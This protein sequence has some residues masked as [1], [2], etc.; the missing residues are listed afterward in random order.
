[1]NDTLDLK[2][3]V[4]NATAQGP[5]IEDD[6]S[7]TTTAAVVAVDAAGRRVRVSVRGGSVWLPAVAGRYSPSS[8]ARILVDPTSARPVLVLGPVAPRAP[9]VLALVTAGPTSGNLTVTF[10]GASVVLPAPMGAYTVGQSAWVALDDWGLPVLVIG[11]NAATDT[12]GSSG[13]GG[14]G[15][16]PS[17]VVAYATIG[18]QVTGTWRSSVARWDSWNPNRYGLGATPIYQGNA[19]GSGQ[20]LGFAGYGD[21]VANLGA[22]SIDDITMQ[23][24]KGADGNS[25]VLTVQGSGSGTRPGGAPTSGGDTAST[26]SIASGATGGLA[27]TANMRE[28]FRTGAAKGLVAIGSQYGGFGGVGVPPSFVLQIRYT[29]NA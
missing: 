20:L 15:G 25:A 17:T 21:Q 27:F 6:T 2:T 1:M 14:G 10:D 12:G 22:V 16:A 28:A 8:M 19:Y 18:P 26:G 29:K 5:G 3:L 23:A 24:V 4:K 11:P 9:Y 13:G 7:L